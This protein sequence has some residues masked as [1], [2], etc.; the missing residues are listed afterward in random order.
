MNLLIFLQ[1]EAIHGL[2]DTCHVAQ[3]GSRPHLPVGEL[4][5]KNEHFLSGSNNA[6]DITTKQEVRPEGALDLQSLMRG[7]HLL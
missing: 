2:E 1:P 4:V 7:R 5:P 6:L 3:W